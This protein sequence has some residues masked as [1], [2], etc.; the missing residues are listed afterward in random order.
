[1]SAEM[2]WLPCLTQAE[3][4]CVGGFKFFI[5]LHVSMNNHEMLRML[6]WGLQISFSKEVNSHMQD[7][8]E[9]R[10]DWKI[11]R[12]LSAMVGVWVT[13]SSYFSALLIAWIF[14]FRSIIWDI[15]K[16]FLHPHPLLFY[17]KMIQLEF[18][19][20]QP[21]EFWL[22]REN[23]QHIVGPQWMWVSSFMECRVG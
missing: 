16:S 15:A 23:P 11:K 22:S 21:K 5:T 4:V 18:C 9:V 20:L 7:A 6:I 2:S 17:P 10:I 1:M 3:N 19:C 13:D 12:T 14:N 8:W